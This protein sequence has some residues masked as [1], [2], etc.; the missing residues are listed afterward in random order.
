M[1]LTSATGALGG[2]GL[3]LVLPSDAFE[4][5][6]PALILTAAVLIGSNH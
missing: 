6:V 1:A 5:A 2:A 3:L 4:A